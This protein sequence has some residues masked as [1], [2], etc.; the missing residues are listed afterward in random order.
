MTGEGVYNGQ[1]IAGG[2]L[3]FMSGVVIHN[4]PFV[5]EPATLV[6]LAGMAGM[7]LILVARRR[8]QAAA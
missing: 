5:P 4:V 6:G 1:V 7:G 2:N 3:T 8:R